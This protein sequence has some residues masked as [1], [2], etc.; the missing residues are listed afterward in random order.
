MFTYKHNANHTNLVNK[1]GELAL[2]K[3]RVH[4]I[5]STVG[6]NLRLANIE[7]IA[8]PIKLCISVHILGGAQRVSHTL[9]GVDNRASEV[10]GGIHLV[11][12]TGTR[13]CFLLASEDGRIAHTPVVRVHVDLGTQTVSLTFFAASLHLLP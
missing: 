12:V 7:S 4:Q 11:S 13:M 10:I 8:K 3:H 6:G 1:E 5:Q 9:E 2:R